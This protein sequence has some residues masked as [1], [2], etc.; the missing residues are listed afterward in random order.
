MDIKYKREKRYDDVHKA[1]IARCKEALTE[2]HKKVLECIYYTFKTETH[3]TRAGD[4]EK[5]EKY[6]LKEPRV[7]KDS[8]VIDEIKQNLSRLFG[9][10]E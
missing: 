3:I 6:P 7:I 9:R 4:Y 2:I 8:K 10:K 1:H 5:I